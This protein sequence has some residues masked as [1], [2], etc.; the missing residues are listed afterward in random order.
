MFK[1]IFDVVDEEDNVIGKASRK[2][3]HKRKLIHRSVM[4]FIFDEEKRVFVTKRTNN[5]DFFPRYWSIVLGGHV[6]SG[7]SY[8]DA[9][10]R[11]IAEET[12]LKQKPFFMESFKKRIPEEKEN[13]RVYGVVASGEIILNCHEL[14]HGE[15][16]SLKELEKKLKKEKFLPETEILLPILRRYLS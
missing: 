6:N 16:L 8:E 3:C 5:K 4:F 14:Q 2:E 15:F 1:E 9:A 12:G 10:I 7:E 13:V 11:E